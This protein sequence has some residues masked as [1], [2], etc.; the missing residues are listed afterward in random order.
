M[1]TIAAGA[2]KAKCLAIMDEVQ[3]RRESVLITKNGKPIARL[4]PVEEEVDSIFGFYAG[5]LKVHGD[6]DIPAIPEK[7]WKQLR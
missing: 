4:V 1:Q 2:F 7:E 5:A 6:V 3:A